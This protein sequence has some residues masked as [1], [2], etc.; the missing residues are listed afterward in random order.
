MFPRGAEAATDGAR[1]HRLMFGDDAPH[2]L[3]RAFTD[4]D[5]HP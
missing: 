1:L 4:P 3:V 2:G 5:D